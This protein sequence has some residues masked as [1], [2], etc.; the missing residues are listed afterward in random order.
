[1]KAGISRRMRGQFQTVR[2]KTCARDIRR[3]PTTSRLGIPVAALDMYLAEALMDHFGDRIIVQQAGKSVSAVQQK[4]Q[5]EPLGRASL[6]KL[7]S[8]GIL[9]VFSFSP[10]ILPATQ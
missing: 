9:P 3:L 5:R 10:C 7:T 1:V 6:V 2:Q 4:Q 8:A